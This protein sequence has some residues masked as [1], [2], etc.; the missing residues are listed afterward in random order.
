MDIKVEK[1]V[2]IALSEDSYNNDITSQALIDSFLIYL[3]SNK[4]ITIL[5][6]FF[7]IR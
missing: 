2:E 6:C 3:F 7:K 1:I 5:T 4:L